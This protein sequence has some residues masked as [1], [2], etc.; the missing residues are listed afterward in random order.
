MDEKPKP[1]FSGDYNI[2]TNSFEDKKLES[3]LWFSLNMIWAESTSYEKNCKSVVGLTVGHPKWA[4]TI[5]WGMSNLE[6]LGK[7][8]GNK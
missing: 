1:L 4:A 7:K 8:I 3:A 6:E 2:M 5:E